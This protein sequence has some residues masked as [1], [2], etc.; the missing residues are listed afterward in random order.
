MHMIALLGIPMPSFGTRR[1]K[2]CDLGYGLKMYAH[3]LSMQAYGSHSL[4][5]TRFGGQPVGGVGSLVASKTHSFNLE[6]G[7]NRHRNCRAGTEAI[8]EKKASQ[9][10]FRDVY[11]C[12]MRTRLLR[13][14]RESMLSQSP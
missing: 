12:K 6:K 3:R 14:T 1:P 7:A 11:N 9:G 4:F 5:K 13:Q 10:E 8:R 2:T